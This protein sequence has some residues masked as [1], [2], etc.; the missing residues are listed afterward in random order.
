MRINKAKE[1]LKTIHG[2]SETPEERSIRV[3]RLGKNISR[4][5]DA[6]QKLRSKVGE[7]IQL[8]DPPTPKEE[9][10]S[11]VA[12]DTKEESVDPSATQEGRKD[13]DLHM[14]DSSA[15]LK[16]EATPDAN[17]QNESLDQKVP[18]M[19]EDNN[20]DFENFND[21]PAIGNQDED[22]SMDTS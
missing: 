16:V 3:E 7:R 13:E 9:E 2:L 12:I 14:V 5:T 4:K 8:P 17:L 20:F 18:F 6:L 10:E 19:T 11:E 1:I 15:A 21:F 22:I